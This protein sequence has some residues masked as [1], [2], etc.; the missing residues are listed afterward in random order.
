MTVLCMRSVSRVMQSNVCA[1]RY[2]PNP[3]V[4]DSMSSI[5][6]T[7][8]PER[9]KALAQH[10][11]AVMSDLLTEM[12]SRQWRNRHAACLAA[13]DVLQVPFVC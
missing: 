1:C 6:T 2:D 5:L 12:V 11:D 10:F 9:Q 7:I 8:V 3:H 13:A 4:Q